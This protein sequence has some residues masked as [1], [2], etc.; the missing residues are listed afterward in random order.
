V[1]H[2]LH[3]LTPLAHFSSLV[4][5]LD[6]Y[7]DAGVKLRTARILE[8]ISKHDLPAKFTYDPVVMRHLN[9]CLANEMLESDE[10][11]ELGLLRYTLASSA[12]PENQAALCDCGLSSM[13]LHKLTSQTISLP[14]TLLIMQTFMN[15]ARNRENH[16]RM[17]EDEGMLTTLT[18]HVFHEMANRKAT[19]SSIYGK[20][21]MSVFGDMTSKAASDASENDVALSRSREAAMSVETVRKLILIV[22]LL[23]EVPSNTAAIIESFVLTN[24]G[25]EQLTEGDIKDDRRIRQAVAHIMY[26]LATYSKD[27][28]DKCHALGAQGCF[29]LAKYYL[30]GHDVGRKSYAV[31]VL[32]IFSRHTSLESFVA[33]DEALEEIVALGYL[34]DDQM[35]VVELLERIGE[36][37]AFRLAMLKAGTVTVLLHILKAHDAAWA[38][39][40]GKFREELVNTLLIS[41]DR[42]LK[43]EGV[44]E[45]MIK[46]L[47]C[48]YR[49]SR[50][51]KTL[52]PPP[53]S[54]TAKIIMR[55]MRE[56]ACAFQ[57]Q[58]YV[59]Q[60]VAKIRAR[61][62]LKIEMEMRAR[63]EEQ[64]KALRELQDEQEEKPFG[65]EEMAV[66]AE[67]AAHA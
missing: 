24:V 56:Q 59:S 37:P 43:M 17:L 31:Q 57:I 63:E 52:I 21:S 6:D 47:G 14:H 61:K 35:A 27:S 22:L 32:A 8:R 66:A 67:A 5:L 2:P 19:R 40:T 50:N 53:S 13:L 18:K 39:S 64:K 55:K 15:L 7:N 42:L 16:V 3:R 49:L 25:V 1:Q 4:S 29:D 33:S 45:Q 20:S 30:L 10:A 44:E 11:I 54:L 60:F 9:T 46:V 58:L 38:S 34:P 36:L 41:L 62:A 28:P 12:H 26:R 48:I 23:S 51:R 65:R